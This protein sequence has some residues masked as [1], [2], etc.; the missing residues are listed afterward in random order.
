M[1]V[2]PTRKS[3]VSGASFSKIAARGHS[4]SLERKENLLDTKVGLVSTHLHKV[5]AKSIRIEFRL[6]LNWTP[7]TSLDSL[8]SQS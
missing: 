5:R 7:M 2:E 8:S 1:R 3:K 4:V 6:G